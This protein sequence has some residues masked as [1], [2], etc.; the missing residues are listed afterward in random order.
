MK[1]KHIGVK[2]GFPRFKSIDRMKSL[3]YPQFG[4]E[5]GE[6]LKV[7]PFGELSIVKHRRIAGTIKT[8]TIKRE[9]TGKWFAC[10]AVEQEK[11]L[12]KENN[13]RKV[14][15]DLGLKSLATLSDG[16]VISNPKHLLRHEERLA[17]L[18]RRLSRAKKRSKN[19]LKVRLKVARL[20]EKVSD[21]RQDFLHKTSTQ[22]VNNYSFLALER[23]AT[24]EMAEQRFGK[25]IND[26]GWNMFA[27]M[28]AYKA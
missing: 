10:F 5:L 16:T 17:F 27:N 19:R 12:P 4:F 25:Q 24:K 3:H 1:M 26:A 15:I 13:G 28:L 21:V 7:T 23:L 8:L 14:G 9:P 6:K 18:Q 11:V 20:H 22:L 2:C